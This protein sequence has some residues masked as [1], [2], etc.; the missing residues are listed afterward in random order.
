MD[1]YDVMMDG[2]GVL[3]RGWYGVGGMCKGRV[4]LWRNEV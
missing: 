1:L 3:N 4:G 2:G